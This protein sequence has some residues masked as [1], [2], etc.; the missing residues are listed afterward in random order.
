M[1]VERTARRARTREEFFDALAAE[2]A[3]EADR[4]KFLASFR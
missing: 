1:V 2:I 4:K 3:S